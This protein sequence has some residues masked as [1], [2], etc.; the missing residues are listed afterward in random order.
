MSEIQ[1]KTNID[2]WLHIPSA[3][4]IADILTKS[5]T[6]N[7]IGPDSIWQNGPSWLIRDISLWP[8]TDTCLDSADHETIAKFVCKAKSHQISAALNVSS[9]T[10]TGNVHVFDSL[11]EKIIEV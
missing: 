1:K 3:E 6:P 4:N 5:T 10:H 2:S 8:I 7:N 11:M 9:Q